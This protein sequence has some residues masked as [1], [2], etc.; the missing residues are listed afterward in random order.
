MEILQQELIELTQC[1]DL[2]RNTNDILTDDHIIIE[3]RISLESK[4]S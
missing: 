3:Q 2:Y 1:D 4:W